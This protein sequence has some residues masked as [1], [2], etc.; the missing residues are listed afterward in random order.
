MFEQW[1]ERLKGS[2]L[3]RKLDQRRNRESSA[4]PQ[5]TPAVSA[6]TPKEEDGGGPSEQ[7]TTVPAP[8]AREKIGLVILHS[9]ETAAAEYVFTMCLVVTFF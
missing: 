4:E 1:F 9:E 3:W 7:A 5:E 2:R 8:M 6:P